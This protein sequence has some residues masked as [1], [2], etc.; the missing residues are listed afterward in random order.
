MA[1]VVATE[2]WEAIS[3]EDAVL[4]FWHDAP[5]QLESS[6]WAFAGLKCE[7]PGPHE[8]QAGLVVD[9]ECSHQLHRR[10]PCG[11]LRTVFGSPIKR[12]SLKSLIIAGSVDRS[13]FIVAGFFKAARKSFG[14]GG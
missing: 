10:R 7:G 6:F 4:Q 1:E 8:L 14:N 13:D 3:N 5:H 12:C 11:I 2:T 9:A